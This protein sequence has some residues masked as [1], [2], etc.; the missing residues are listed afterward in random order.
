MSCNKNQAAV[1]TPVLAAGSVASPYFYQVNI[2]QRL[3]FPTCVTNTPVFAPQFSI[4]SLATVGKGQY[5]ATLHVEGIVSYTPY[6]GGC[7]CNKQQPISQDFTIPIQSSSVPTVTI[8]QGAAANSMAATGCHP[9][10]RMFVS[11]T[12]VTVTVS[13][14]ATATK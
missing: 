12:P 8:S 13:V 1:I 6:N 7:G 5:V 9:C 14:P 4:V 11:E 2:T 3:C 10:S